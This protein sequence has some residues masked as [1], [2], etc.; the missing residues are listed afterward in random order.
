[1]ATYVSS[2]DIHD[3][4]DHMEPGGVL[5]YR[6]E[7]ARSARLLRRLLQFDAV[8]VA[9]AG[10]LTAIFSVPLASFLG[11]SS[12]I[13][14]IVLGI[15][16][17]PYAAQLFIKANRKLL[18]PRLGIMAGSLNIA[19]VLASLLIVLA[20]WPPLSDQGKWAVL[21]MAAVVDLLGCAQL[22][23]ARKLRLEAA[24]QPE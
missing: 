1:M 13:P 2:D 12:P 9:I 10:S 21:G 3:S 19:W 18:D 6:H 8:F 11:L 22:Y 15:A 17:I 5:Q 23:A 7:E 24:A 14:L 4:Q 16:L 20:G